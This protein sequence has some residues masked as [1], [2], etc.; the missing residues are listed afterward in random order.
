MSRCR[1]V[2]VFS[3]SRARLGR[4]LKKNIDIMRK[5][6]ITLIAS[7]S[8]LLCTAPVLSAQKDTLR[9]STLF[10]SHIIFSSDITYANRS[11]D[12]VL[13]SMIVEQNRN[14]IAVRANAPFT[15]PC[16]ISALESNGRMW[17][18]IVVYEKNPSNL[19]VDTRHRKRSRPISRRH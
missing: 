7:L 1:W 11:N 18:F 13:R 8:V 15:E 10:T 3:L 9:V 19:I 16:S 6:L 5:T 4:V 14:M 12:T 2:I 17:T